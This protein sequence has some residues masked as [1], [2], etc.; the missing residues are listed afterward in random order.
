M[1]KVFSVTIGKIVF[2]VE[3][4]AF[5]KLS[6]Y[7]DSIK[8]HFK[9][10]TE[11]KEILEDIE[12]SIA[13]KL[14]ARQ[15]NKDMAIAMEDVEI[16]IKKLGKVEDFG[17]D[18]SDEADDENDKSNKHKEKPYKRLYR[19]ID[20][21]MIAGVCSG[22]AAYFGIDPVIVRL[23]FVISIFFGGLGILAYAILWIITPEAVTTTQKLEMH[24]TS[25]TLQQ[26]EKSIK[27]GIDKIK[28]KDF[29]VTDRFKTVF[30]KIFSIIGKIV[31]ALLSFVRIIGG[32][33]LTVA[34]VS[35]IFLLSFGTAWIVSGGQLPFAD[36]AQI[37]ISDF[38]TVGQV[39]LWFLIISIYIV[40][41]VPFLILFTGGI[42]LL[43]KRVIAKPYFVI[44]LLALWFASLGITGS[45]VIQNADQIQTNI[46]K[47]GAERNV[48]IDLDLPGAVDGN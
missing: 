18:E 34:G 1:K 45:V 33:F 15:K 44:I 30:N 24:G 46:E 11:R 17:N 41:L 35:G 12:T 14:L 21:Q 10:D 40:V 48:N 42:S 19:D 28:K 9:K 26:I 3:E 43:K 32:T 6:A 47:F 8:A 36:Y 20:D 23:S 39:L 22:I 4:D 27:T 25:V 38:I 7:L 13:E 31:R 37:N 5:E 29:R 16:I 2:N